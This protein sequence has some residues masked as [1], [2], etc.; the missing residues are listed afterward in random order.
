MLDNLPE[1][2]EKVIWCDLTPVQEEIYLQ[3]YQ[4]SK[5]KFHSL[6]ESA[7]LNN[8][9]KT[10]E[11]R[12]VQENFEKS[13][14]PSSTLNFILMQ[15]RKVNQTKNINIYIYKNIYIIFFFCFLFIFF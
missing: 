3:T 7:D 6:R 11:D 15:L 1:K 14:N 13:A 5:T 4:S 10:L 8:P 9:V 2:K 12:Q